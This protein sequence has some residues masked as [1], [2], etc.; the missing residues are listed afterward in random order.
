MS[1]DT[2]ILSKMGGFK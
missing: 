1:V 2:S